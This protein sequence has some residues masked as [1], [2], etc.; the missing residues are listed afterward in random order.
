M[1]TIRLLVGFLACYLRL[2]IAL[3]PAALKLPHSAKAIAASLG[4]DEGDAPLASLRRFE[5]RYRLAS[6]VMY[7]GTNFKGWQDTLDPRYRSVQVSH[8]LVSNAY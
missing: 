8:F 7:D 5:K 3:L 6:R 1:K 2:V 4:A